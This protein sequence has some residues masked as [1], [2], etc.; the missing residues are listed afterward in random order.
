MTHGQSVSSCFYRGKSKQTTNQT[1]TLKLKR[2]LTCKE[3]YPTIIEN[4]QTKQNHQLS[5][6]IYSMFIPVVQSC[7]SA[8]VQTSVYAFDRCVDI[9]KQK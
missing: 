9:L 2:G 6:K 3:K 8:T 7:R 4:K 5:H 1:L